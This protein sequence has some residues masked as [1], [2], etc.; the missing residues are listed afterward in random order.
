MTEFVQNHRSQLFCAEQGEHRRGDVNGHWDFS[1][2][3]TEGQVRSHDPNEL[4]LPHVTAEC[5]KVG[6]ALIHVTFEVHNQRVVLVDARRVNAS[7]VK[8]KIPLAQFRAV[9]EVD[10]VATFGQILG[11]CPSAIR[12]LAV[13][14]N[15]FESTNVFC[16]L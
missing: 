12:P 7:E 10:V 14:T 16:N 2:I 1:D 8:V 5:F 6:V 15:G 11:E 13:V 3:A 9:I 4:I